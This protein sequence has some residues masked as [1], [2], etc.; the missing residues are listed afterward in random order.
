MRFAVS[1]VLVLASGLAHASGHVRPGIEYAYPD[2]SVW[3]TRLD[4]NGTP[5]N[6]LLRLAEILF[7]QAEIPWQG[8]AYPASRMFNVLEE[9][10]AQFSMLVRAPRLESCCL[11]G[12][13]PVAST[14]LRV[15]RA[16]DQAPI[17]DQADLAGKTVIAIRGYSYGGLGAYLADPANGVTVNTAPGHDAAF[18]MLERDRADYLLDYA[19]P[20]TEVLARHP[21]A[22]LAYDVL[23]HLDVFL[24]LN[25]TYPDAPKVLERLEA[26]LETLDREAIPGLPAAR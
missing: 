19:G 14:E 12:R 26:I 2:Q 13:N 18:A 3:T 6:P 23:S 17:K 4:A 1:A 24:V 21:Q 10:R 11:L 16:P 20:A 15:Y 22:D 9:G 5:D 25:R 7:S 8:R